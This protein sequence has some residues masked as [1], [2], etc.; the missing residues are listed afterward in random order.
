MTFIFWQNF[1]SIHQSAFLRNLAEKHNV[2]LVTSEKIEDNRIKQGWKIPDFGKVKIVE[3]NSES[4][5]QLIITKY[6]SA[7]HIFSGFDLT[8]TIARALDFAVSQNLQIGVMS[9]PFRWTGIKGKLRWLKYFYYY[10]KYS[11]KIKFLLLTGPKAIQWFRKAGFNKKSLFPWGYFTEISLETKPSTQKDSSDKKTDLLFIGQLI[12]RKNIIELIITIKKLTGYFHQF[13][14][15]GDGPLREDVLKMIDA[16]KNIEYLGVL[17]NARVSEIL[18]ESDILVLPSKFDGWGAVV[19]ESLQTGT[20][21]IVSENCG[22]SDLVD[23]QKR[24]E[25]FYFSGKNNLESVLKNWMKKG[26][27]SQNT[28]SEIME[29]SNK[30]ISGKFT[31]DYFIEIVEFINDSSKIRPEAPWIKNRFQLLDFAPSSQL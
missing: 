23:G 3:I 5:I 2:V 30:N 8:T 16:Y 6:E 7:W 12:D 15:V 22:A 25:I 10:L 28:R 14:I 29:W 17:S 9:E 1:V 31:A 21:V 19:N 26:K 27:V 18:Q 11:R 20:P 13:R 24:G 4:E